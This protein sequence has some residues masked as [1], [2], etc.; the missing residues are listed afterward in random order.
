MKTA[1]LVVIVFLFAAACKTQPKKIVLSDNTYELN[2]SDEFDGET[3]DTEK[4]TFRKD[5]KHWSTQKKENVELKDGFLNLNLK[6]EKALDKEYT[7]GGIIS[8]DTFSYGYYEARLR[9]PDGAGWHTSFWLMKYGN[10]DTSTDFSKIEIDIL[11]NDS[12]QFN[13]YEIAFHKYVGGHKSV[14]GQ[15]V[16]VPNMN[17]QFNVIACEYTAD[18]VKYYINGEQVKRLDISKI[19]Q[20]DVNIWATSIASHLGG[21]K[22]V[23]D[24]KL[25]TAAT[26][27]YIRYYKLVNDEN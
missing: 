19:E 16:P 17:E 24:N 7:G 2:F 13:G 27:D 11:E 26:F 5:S 9:I 18:F 15:H 23:D 4:W 22:M 12:K 21:T 1:I 8:I 10:G 25:P 14:F 6:K 20:G 3:I